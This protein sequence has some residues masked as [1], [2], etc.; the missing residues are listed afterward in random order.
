MTFRVSVRPLVRL[1]RVQ[2]EAKGLCV[3]TTNPKSTSKRCAECG[4]IHDDDRLSR[5]TFECQKCGNR[6]HADYNAAKNVAVVYFRREQQSSRWRGVSQYA[7]KYGIMTPN[8]GYTSYAEASE[9][10]S[11][12]KPHLLRSP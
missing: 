12:D 9:A 5:D 4:F 10:E 7:L 8:W 2:T 6:N 11:A 3:D 1:R